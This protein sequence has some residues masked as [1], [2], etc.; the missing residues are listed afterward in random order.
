M[1][2]NAQQHASKPC[3]AQVIMAI[4]APQIAA[5]SRS[6]AASSESGVSASDVQMRLS[7][8]KLQNK[9]KH[10]DMPPDLRRDVER[11]MGNR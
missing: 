5:A 8:W 7:K 6:I 10:V 11:V 3:A 4:T 9:G 2:R 1:L